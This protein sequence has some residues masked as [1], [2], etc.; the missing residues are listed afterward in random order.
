MNR[1]IRD[2]F[3]KVSPGSPLRISATAW[4]S[5]LDSIGPTAQTPGAG[6]TPHSPFTGIISVNNASGLDGDR[7]HVFGLTAAAITYNANPDE[8]LRAVLAE[9]DLPDDEL[10]FAIAVEAIP[11]G[12]IGEAVVVGAVQVLLHVINENHRFALVESGQ[13]GFLKTGPT[14]PAQIVWKEAAEDRADPDYAWAIV[15]LGG[16]GSGAAGVFPVT[17]TIDGG[18]AGS[19]STTC[20][21]TYEVK[22]LDT[23][24]IGTAM[25]PE[26]R[27]F[28]NTPYTATPANSPGLAYFDSDGALHLFDANELPD[29]EEECP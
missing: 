14:G 19:I 11:D 15:I 29:S 10:P 13:M 26:K 4:N 17:V 5:M 3:K 27:R 2:P 7:Y 8:F 6:P 24:V 25:T 12:Y 22:A 21:Y 28:P 1:T 16:G 9:G 18:S 23:S 20:S